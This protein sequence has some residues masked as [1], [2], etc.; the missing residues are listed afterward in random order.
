MAF[1]LRLLASIMSSKIDSRAFQTPVLVKIYAHV[2]R[3]GRKMM[4]QIGII[5]RLDKRSCVV[6]VPVCRFPPTVWVGRDLGA[7]HGGSPGSGHVMPLRLCPVGSK[8]REIEK[9]ELNVL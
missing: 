6:F 5:L 4:A 8:K 7:G 2:P 3:L 1:T 9:A